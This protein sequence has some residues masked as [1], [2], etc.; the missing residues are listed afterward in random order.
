MCGNLLAP[1][2]AVFLLRGFPAV[3]QKQESGKNIFLEISAEL[4]I[5][6]RIS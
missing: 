2:S 4:Y 6:G 5:V 3:A 1:S